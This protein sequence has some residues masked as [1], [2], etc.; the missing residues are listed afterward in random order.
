MNLDLKLTLQPFSVFYAI[1]DIVQMGR[2]FFCDHYF[3]YLLYFLTA[4]LN[5][6]VSAR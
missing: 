4:A 1:E 3:F 5:T 2:K 6:S